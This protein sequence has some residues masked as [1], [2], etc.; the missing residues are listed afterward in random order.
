MSKSPN[1]LLP[2]LGVTGVVLG[3]AYGTM[4][5][6]Y[7]ADEAEIARAQA[8]AAQAQL[9]EQRA[10]ASDLKTQIA[11]VQDTAKAKIAELEARPAASA[12][13]TAP[14]PEREGAFG[15]GRKALVE[16]IAA[17]DVDVLPD[18]RG[19]PIGT[20]NAL[21]GEELF[22]DRCAACHG[23]FA[24]GVDNWPV[25]AGGFNT[26]ADEDPV[27]TV[28]SYWPH[29]STVYDYVYRSMPFGE[30]GTLSPDETYAIVA[31]ILYSNDL[32][33]GEFELGNK[34][35]GSFEMPNKDGFVIDDRPEAEYAAW[36]AEPCMSNCKDEVTV[37]MRSVF[38]VNTPEDGG[39]ESVINDATPEGLPSFT[40]AGA[41]FIPEAEAQPEAAEEVAAVAAE[42]PVNEAAELIA[43]GDK[44]FKKC[45]ACHAVG[46]GAK[47]KSGP[48]LNALMGRK[49][50]SIEG[51]KYSKVFKAAAEKGRTWDATSLS[52]FL[53]KPKAYMKGTKM[54][55][56]GLKKD[57]DLEAISAYLA[58]FSE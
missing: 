10:M 57:S 18:G 48:Q 14:A 36:S 31:Y 56:S 12:S 53:A 3:G 28:G 27:K 37:T 58:S 1:I 13:L 35:L 30:A 45:K 23:D 49:M 26:L 21:D 15:L 38:L 17:W 39:S 2:A 52:E 55:F 51:F 46:A 33:D 20:G 19:L 25:L 7:K 8:Q 54:S 22:A 6:G 4:T 11:M 43:A 24:E 29:L 47:N 16:E 34:T 32:I 9:V 40:A 50:G 42:E 44:V 41:S 5:R